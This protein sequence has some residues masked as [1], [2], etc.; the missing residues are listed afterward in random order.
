MGTRLGHLADA[1]TKTEH[2]GIPNVPLDVCW[3][4]WTCVT[5]QVKCTVFQY[6]D[7]VEHLTT[8]HFIVHFVTVTDLQAERKGHASQAVKPHLKWM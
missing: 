7:T 1:I 2:F 5:I 8:K 4:S 3:Q 6:I